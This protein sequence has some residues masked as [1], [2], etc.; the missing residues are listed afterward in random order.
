MLF[1]DL[2]PQKSKPKPRPLDAMSIADL[3]A[4]IAELKAEIARV[5]AAIATKSAH[6]ASAAALFKRPS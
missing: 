2:E 1:D 6:M 3:G 5:E 4:Y